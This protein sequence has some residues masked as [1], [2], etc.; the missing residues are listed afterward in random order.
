MTARLPYRLRQLFSQRL[1]K[2]PPQGWDECQGEGVIDGLVPK[3]LG[4]ELVNEDK[5]IVVVDGKSK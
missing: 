4:G 5:Y 1:I 2:T 3:Q